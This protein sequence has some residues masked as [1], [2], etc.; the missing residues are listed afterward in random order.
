MR[1]AGFTLV[2]VL[3]AITILGLALFILLQSQWGALNIH[4]TINEE[5][6][7]SQLV[8][9]IAGKAEI[10]VLSGVLSDGGDFG[11]RYPDYL[12]N[13]DAA[14]RGDSEDQENQLYE[15]IITI[16]GPESEKS[17]KFYV[18]NNNPEAN[19]GGIFNEG[20]GSGRG[21]TSGGRGNSGGRRN[22]GGGR[23][24]GLF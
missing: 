18:Y 8:D 14:L 12:W 9:S 5:V 2:E 6:T 7:L 24:G 21:G 1:R 19:E 3:A 23:S 10:G 13:Y 11:T 16:E 15:V 20:A 4:A 22:N 17:L